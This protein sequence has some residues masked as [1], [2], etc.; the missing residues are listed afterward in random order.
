MEPQQSRAKPKLS[1]AEPPSLADLHERWRIECMLLALLTDMNQPGKAKLVLDD[2]N[3]VDTRTSTHA[4]LLHHLS[5]LITRN[6]E[7]TATN[8]WGPN[9][10]DPSVHVNILASESDDGSADNFAAVLNP[11]KKLGSPPPS[12]TGDSFDIKV[13]LAEKGE[14]CWDKIKGYPLEGDK[15]FRMK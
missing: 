11:T 2:P 4:K 3:L 8:S 9:S 10:A 14:S 6:I 15:I 1:P 7:V 5:L 12:C 13:W